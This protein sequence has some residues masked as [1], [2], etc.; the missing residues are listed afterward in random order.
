[1]SWSKLPREVQRLIFEALVE[2]QYLSDALTNYSFG[3][4]RARARLL[5]PLSLVSLQ[6][7]VGLLTLVWKPR[8]DLLTRMLPPCSVGCYSSTSLRFLGARDRLESGNWKEQRRSATAPSPYLCV[9]QRT[10]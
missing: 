3:L 4:C 1:M 6:W 9:T 7:R 10:D 8:K 2:E 5:A